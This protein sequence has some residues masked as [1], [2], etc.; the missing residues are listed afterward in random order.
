[1][2]K[3]LGDDALADAREDYVAAAAKGLVGLVPFAGSLLAEIAGAIIPNQR[4]DRVADYA[5]KLNMRLQGVEDKLVEYLQNGYFTDLMEEGLRQAARAVSDERKEYIASLIANSLTKEQV[6]FVQS[7][8]LLR[9]LGELNDIEILW[10]QAYTKL[11]KDDF[12]EFLNQHNEALAIML[13]GV[14]SPHSELEKAAVQDSYRNHLV[15]IGLL[16]AKYEIDSETKLPS[17]NEF[18]GRQE[19]QR[20]EITTLGRFLLNEIGLPDGLLYKAEA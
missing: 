18:T 16:S 17:F 10:L 12:E 6:D 9:M 20:Y 11:A 3:N 14:N 2:S 7:V 5:Q 4:L 19:I 8:H 13:P 1:M 15:R